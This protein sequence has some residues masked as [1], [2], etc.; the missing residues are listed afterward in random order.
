MKK[1]TIILTLFIF[2]TLLM[3]IFISMLHSGIKIMATHKKIAANNI[4]TAHYKIVYSNSIKQLI[5]PF[6]EGFQINYIF[7]RDLVEEVK[8][9]SEFYLKSRL[10]SGK[11]NFFI[12]VN[13]K[14]YSYSLELFNYSTDSDLDG[15]PDIVELISQTD[16]NNFVNW[17]VNIAES[18]FYQKS[19]TWAKVH[20]DCAGLIV[21]SYKEALKKHNTQWLKKY[22]YLLTHNIPDIQKYN[23]PDIPIIKT[24]IFRTKSGAFNKSDKISESFANVSDA[25]NLLN[26]NMNFV[27]KNL[28]ELKKGDVIFFHRPEHMNMPYHSMVFNGNGFFIYHTGPMDNKPEGEVRKLNLNLL[29]KHPDKAWHPVP[30]NPNFI[31]IFRWKIIM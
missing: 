20:H 4:S 1:N 12:I 13:Q 28:D 31:G 15:F 10:K 21:F 23:Y 3:F 27:S 14:K 24:A 8:N 16:K 22:S 26:F 2:F 5:Y 11:V 17:F 9:N 18:Q 7:G 30:D 29:N 19:Y 25:S 6:K